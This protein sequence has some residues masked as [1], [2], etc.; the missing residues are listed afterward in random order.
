MTLSD[1]QLHEIESA[2]RMAT[3]GPWTMTP[4]RH[5]D[6][7]R[8]W[9]HAVSETT[10]VGDHCGPRFIGSVGNGQPG[11]RRQALADAAFV[12]TA[13]TDV[14]ALV[15]EVRRLRHQFRD[16]Q[17]VAAALILAAGGQITV[18]DETLVKAQGATLERTDLAIRPAT[19]WRVLPQAPAQ[20]RDA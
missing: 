1:E 7:G 3:P 4:D 17:V 20:E 8:A 15:A 2:A 14:P 5:A 12:A 11:R 10:H 19:I 13:R 16:A 9:L 18:T 6:A